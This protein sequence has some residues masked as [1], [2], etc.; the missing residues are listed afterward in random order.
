[1]NL[2]PDAV[3]A[4]LTRLLVQLCVQPRLDL[5]RDTLLADIPGLDSLRLIQAVALLEEHFDVEVSTLSLEDLHH[6]GDIV[7]AIAWSP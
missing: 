4:E 2:S 5:T 1:M 3:L 6:V 7:D